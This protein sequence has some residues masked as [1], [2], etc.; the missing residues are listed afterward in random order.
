MNNLIN[1]ESIIYND[2]IMGKIKLKDLIEFMTDMHKDI[3]KFEEIIYDILKEKDFDNKTIFSLLKLNH[4]SGIKLVINM[5]NT[6]E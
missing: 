1:K 6:L 4:C 5:L 2:Y 3:I